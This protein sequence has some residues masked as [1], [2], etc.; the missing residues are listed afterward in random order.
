MTSHP[1]AVVMS[2][3][4]HM[5]PFI[6]RGSDIGVRDVK[7]LPGSSDPAGG[8]RQHLHDSD[9]RRSREGVDICQ[10][11][12]PPTDRMGLTRATGATSDERWNVRRQL[13]DVTGPAPAADRLA[14]SATSGLPLVRQRLRRLLPLR[15]LKQ[16]WCGSELLSRRVA[17]LPAG[18]HDELL[19]PAHAGDRLLLRPRLLLRQNDDP[20]VL[21]NEPRRDRP[22]TPADVRPDPDHV[23]LPDRV[24]DLLRQLRRGGLHVHGELDLTD[25]LVVDDERGHVG[26][27]LV[28]DGIVQDV[29]FRRQVEHPPH[30]TVLGSPPPDHASGRTVEAHLIL[31]DPDAHLPSSEDHERERGTRLPRQVDAIGRGLPLGLPDAFVYDRRRDELPPGVHRGAG[32]RSEVARPSSRATSEAPRSPAATA[33]PRPTP[34]CAPVSLRPSDRRRGRRTVVL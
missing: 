26:P 2:T 1:L 9:G 6:P 21:I 29:E 5:G 3:T 10:R 32:Y 17:T 18:H 11:S 33:G 28:E 8:T 30:P 13:E 19:R 22:S 27:R 15:T 24:L 14:G 7:R 23:G 34:T 20:P 16:A 25:D 12:H 31:H 4:L